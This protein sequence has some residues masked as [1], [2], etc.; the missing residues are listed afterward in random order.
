[1]EP[2]TLVERNLT[3]GPFHAC[4]LR[5]GAALLPCPPRA[6]GCADHFGCDD[7]ARALPCPRAGTPLQAIPRATRRR[8]GPSLLPR[9]E[10]FASLH[11]LTRRASEGSEALPSLARRVSMSFFGARVISPPSSPGKQVSWSSYNQAVAAL[12]F[13]YRVTY[14]SNTVVTRKGNLIVANQD[15]GEAPTLIPEVSLKRCRSREEERP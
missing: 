9:Q 7:F 13:F 11:I 12:R 5:A 2:I 15:R 1:M 4:S 6:A 14:P 3:V 8:P 10:S